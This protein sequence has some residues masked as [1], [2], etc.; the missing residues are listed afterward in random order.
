MTSCP[1]EFCDSRIEKQRPMHLPDADAGTVAS[2]DDRVTVPP[3]PGIPPETRYRNRLGDRRQKTRSDRLRIVC[4]RHAGHGLP[5][6]GNREAG[7]SRVSPGM[8]R[9]GVG[10]LVIRASEG[11]RRPVCREQA[12][13]T[14]RACPAREGASSHGIGEEAGDLVR[15]G[16]CESATHA[17]CRQDRLQ[18]AAVGGD[19]EIGVPRPMASNTFPVTIPRSST[20]ASSSTEVMTTA[21]PAPLTAESASL[22]ETLPWTTTLS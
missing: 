9:S 6:S 11:L 4:D 8:R 18:I 15:F 17:G 22:R 3:C 21:T 10:L 7:V 1:W 14:L 12:M 20:L 19:R 13:K 2:F 5:V 16:A